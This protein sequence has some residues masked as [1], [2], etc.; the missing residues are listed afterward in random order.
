MEA[1]VKSN[2]TLSYMIYMANRWGK[3]EA[4]KIYGE[5]LGNH[6]WEKYMSYA[7]SSGMYAAYAKLVFELDSD[8][9]K[10]LLDRA[11]S[12]YDGS[13]YRK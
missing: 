12:I 10:L 1:N 5:M 3:D 4:V 8:N 7:N 13:K 9:L 11:T 6:I 2:E